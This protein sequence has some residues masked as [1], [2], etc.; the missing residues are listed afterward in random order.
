MARDVVSVEIRGP[1]CQNLTLIDLPGIVRTSGKSESVTLSEDIQG[2]MNEY[3][4]NPRCVILAVLPS[5]VDFHNSQILS[6]ARKVDP[7][8]ERTI[9]VLTKPDLIDDGAQAAVK[10]LRL[11]KKTDVFEMGFHMVKGKLVTYFV[12]SY[13]SCITSLITLNRS[14]SSCSEQE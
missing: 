10:D 5:N 14:G 2:L 1:H 4:S 3:L 12:R 6:Q 8:T 7:K 9:P 13:L 11:G